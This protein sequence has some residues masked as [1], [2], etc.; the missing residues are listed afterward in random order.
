MIRKF[1]RTSF[2]CYCF[3]IFKV[4]TGI[5]DHFNVQLL[6]RSLKKNPTTDKL[7]S[8]TH[9]SI[10]LLTFFYPSNNLSTDSI[11][12]S[13]H[14]STHSLTYTSVH[15]LIPQFIHPCTKIHDFVRG[16]KVLWEN[17][18]CEWTQSFLRD[19][20]TFAKALKCIYFFT[21]L[22]FFSIMSR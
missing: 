10:H 5:F 18:M 13:S 7:Y 3:A 4:F 15:P 12:R 21:H 1:K 16:V 9:P 11:I 19:H 17:A 2:I 6:N 8:L 22:I 14:Q 20:K